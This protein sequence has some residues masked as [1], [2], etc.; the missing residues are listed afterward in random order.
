[1]PNWHIPHYT[2]GYWV[3]SST[4]GNGYL[5]EAV[6]AL[7]HYAFVQLHAKK[8]IIKCDSDNEKSI[9]LI[10]KLNFKSEGTLK[11]DSLRPYL[12]EKARVYRD[13]LLFAN[14]DIKT[15]PKII[16]SWPK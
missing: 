11:F 9:K 16:V 8:L 5:S 6:N 2:I 1:M 4:K 10:K 14:T 13:S 3:R 15:L 12:K 7:A